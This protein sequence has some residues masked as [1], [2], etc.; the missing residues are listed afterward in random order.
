M[1]DKPTKLESR[2]RQIKNIIR[3]SFGVVNFQRFRARVMYSINKSIP[4][5]IK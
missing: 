2:N 4:L 3:N 1:F 5:N